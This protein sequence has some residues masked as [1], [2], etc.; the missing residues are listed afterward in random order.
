MQQVFHSF[1][2]NNLKEYAKQK[3]HSKGL[4]CFLFCFVNIMYFFFFNL[5]KKKFF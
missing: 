3:A 2:T 1:L 5:I 4:I